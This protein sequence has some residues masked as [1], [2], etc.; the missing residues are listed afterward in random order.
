MT[1]ITEAPSRAS[2]AEEILTLARKYHCAAQV[3]MIENESQEISLRKGQIENLLTS[4]AISTGVRL[5]KGKKN[6]IIAFSGENFD[7]METKIKTA[8]ENL[9]YLNEDPHKRLLKPEEFSGQMKTLDLADQHYD[10]LDIP[11]AVNALKEI[12]NHALAYSP[13]ITPAEMAEF[14]GS[15]SHIHIFTSEGLDKSFGKTYYAF[16]YSA[17]AEENDWK[18][19]DYW[20]ES[21]RHF[22]ELPPIEEIGLIGE[23][24]SERALKRLG[25][26]KISSREGKVIFSRRTAGSL[27]G[28]LGDAIDGEEI[29]AKNSFLL[30]RLGEKLFSDKVTLIDDPLRQRFPGSYP[31]DGEGVNGRKKALIEKGQ[32][33]SYIHNSYSAGKLGMKITSNASRSISSAPHIMVGNFYLESGPGS[34]EELT[35]EMKEGLIVEELYV[36]GMNEVTGDFSFGCSGFLV[37]NGKV[38]APVREITIAGNL[39]ELYQNVIGIA[40]DNLWKSSITSP[41]ILVSKLSIGGI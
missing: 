3:T 1:K 35:H 34:P 4:T 2:V 29:V 16:S 21:K 10:E 11:R 18:E 30:D 41:A 33:L 19:R 24:A 31:F 28:L 22:E 12:E 39:L 36:S 7:N 14:S 13:K 6:T 37:E 40:D 20:S 32:L 8:L 23:K 38:T 25:G 17:V 26:K 27:L 9:H 5:F 15:R